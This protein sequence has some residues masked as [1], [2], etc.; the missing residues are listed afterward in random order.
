MSDLERLGQAQ[1]PLTSIVNYFFL[2]VTSIIFILKDKN[3]GHNTNIIRKSLD[4]QL[5]AMLTTRLHSQ[6]T[7]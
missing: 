6:I 7:K 2:F 5:L 3:T 1:R 4:F